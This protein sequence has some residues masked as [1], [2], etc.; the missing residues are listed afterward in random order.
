[1]GICVYV[2]VCKFIRVCTCVCIY[3]CVCPCTCV[4]VYA[5]APLPRCGISQAQEI[6]SRMEEAGRATGLG[7]ES[8]IMPLGAGARAGGGVETCLAHQKHLAVLCDFP[9]QRLLEIGTCRGRQGM[10]RGHEL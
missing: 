4:C 9:F 7:D 6:N 5:L 3:V 8:Q 10:L 2:C 1:M